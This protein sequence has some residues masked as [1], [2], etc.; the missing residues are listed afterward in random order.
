VGF[1]AFPVRSSCCQADHPIPATLRT[2][3]R[4]PPDRSRT[5]SPRPLPS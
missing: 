4:I 3:R 1:A 5:V 2:P